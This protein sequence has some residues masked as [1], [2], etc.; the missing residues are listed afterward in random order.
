M[1]EALLL[2]RLLTSCKRMI[3]KLASQDP[4]H[5]TARP[6]CL[7][8]TVEALEDRALPSAS[9]LGFHAISG[10]TNTSSQMGVLA[11]AGPNLG[12]HHEV[13]AHSSSPVNLVTPTDL[14]RLRTDPSYFATLF[15]AD[16]GRLRAQLGSSFSGVDEQTIAFSMATM[17]AYQLAAY[18]EP[19]DPQGYFPPPR[20]LALADLLAVPKLV[21]NEYC[22]LAAQLYLI[23]FPAAS[24]PGTT[25]TTVG[26]SSSPFGNHAQLLFTSGGVS[27]LGDP[28]LGFVAQTKFSFLRGGGR[29]PA[30][31]IHQLAYRLEPTA[32]VRNIMANFR[33]EVDM[34]L[35]EGL[36]PQAHLVYNRDLT[37]LSL[38]SHSPA[39][40]ISAAAAVGPVVNVPESVSSPAA[41]A[42]TGKHSRPAIGHH[43]TSAA[44][45]EGQPAKK[46]ADLRRGDAETAPVSGHR[47]SALIVLP[48]LTR[49]T[50]ARVPA[51]TSMEL[52][53]ESAGELSVSLD[54]IGSEMPR[55]ARWF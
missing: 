25:I 40:Q 13:A 53:T 47:D 32:Y 1:R 29:L 50:A 34:A 41:V 3:C 18:R 4:R 2:T 16:Q 42:A 26:F 12:S 5:R 33:A 55:P 10:E 14:A 43:V 24:N 54:A 49:D 31:A 46:R 6:R 44:R 8:M 19:N 21:C 20:S 9:L 23:A 52:E 51:A 7:R 37:N 35:E 22:Y 28:T 30:T 27:V 11:T 36:Y 15:Q 39:S 38:V 45:A 17:V 48:P